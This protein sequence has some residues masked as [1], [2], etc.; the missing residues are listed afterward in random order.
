[1]KMRKKYHDNP[2]TLVEARRQIHFWT[3]MPD[4]VVRDLLGELIENKF[5][6]AT[7]VKGKI[8][9]YKIISQEKINELQR[10]YKIEYAE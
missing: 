5:L 2:I 3:R 1:M 9:N 4:V 6:V 7:D 10:R 8:P